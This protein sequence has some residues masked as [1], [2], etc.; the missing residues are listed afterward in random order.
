MMRSQLY[1]L[2]AVLA[3]M[4]TFSGTGL[5][6]SRKA[7]IYLGMNYYQEP[8]KLG[9][10]AYSLPE[11][12]RELRPSFWPSSSGFN[13]SLNPDY[14]IYMDSLNISEYHVPSI[15]NFLKEDFSPVGINYNYHAPALRDFASP[16]WRPTT[17]TQI[18]HV[19]AITNFLMSDWQPSKPEFNE[20]PTWISQFLRA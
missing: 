8:V 17:E 19:P 11:Q 20:Y 9:G 1:I 15:V 14:A 18:Y 12:S 7:P 16:D 2:A 13:F 6:Q 5:D 4:L 10:A 3:I